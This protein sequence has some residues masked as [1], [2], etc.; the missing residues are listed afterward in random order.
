MDFSKPKS[1]MPEHASR[2]SS[3]YSMPA[4][5][6]TNSGHVTFD[7]RGQAVWEWSRPGG[8]V[9]TSSTDTQL[10]K[11]TAVELSLTDAAPRPSKRA[12]DNPA[13]TRK[14]YDPYASGRLSRAASHKAMKK[15]LRK[16]G[17]WLKLKQQV[18]RN[19]RE[20]E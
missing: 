15:D 4:E 16:L 17:E 9:P 3:P 19:K 13:G 20:E 2:R 11:L 1:P 7:D 12:S 5:A 14:G 6:L 8:T 18:E 10:K